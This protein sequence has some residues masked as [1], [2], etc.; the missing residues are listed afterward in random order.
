MHTCLSSG[1][2]DGLLKGIELEYILPPPR[3]EAEAA[4]AAMHATIE[5]LKEVNSG[6]RN[7]FVQDVP[8]G[9][10]TCIVACCQP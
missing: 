4:T 5:R 7:T 6:V 9:I 8:T 2:V 1:A 10:P 3:P